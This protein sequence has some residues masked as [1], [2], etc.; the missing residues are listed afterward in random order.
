VSGVTGLDHLIILVDDLDRG[1]RSMAALGF[2]PTPRGYHSEEMGTANATVVLHDGTYFEVLG[3]VTETEANAPIRAGLAERRTLFGLAMKA[4]DAEAAQSQFDGLTIGAG[5]MRAFS[6]PV[7]LPGGPQDAS[8]RTAYLDGAVKPGAYGFVCQHLTP[9]S[10]WRPD[11]LDQPNA[12][13]GIRR[14]VGVAADP[15]AAVAAWA[16]IPGLTPDGS[17]LRMG[18][19]RLDF[20]QPAAFGSAYGPPPPAMPC[21]AALHFASS[22]LERTRNA[23][24]AGGV[25][26]RQAGDALQANAEGVVF[27]FENA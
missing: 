4:D 9:E 11:F 20:M 6:R 19:R 3:L 27:R 17:G 23:L 18:N 7:D 14:V 5:A 15:G 26:Y 22:D 2:R 21:L 1:E 25:D 16:R 8:F 12:V 13:A 10:V 24:A